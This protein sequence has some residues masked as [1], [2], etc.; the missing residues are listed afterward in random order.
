MKTETNYEL[1]RNNKAIAVLSAVVVNV[2][3]LTCLSNLFSTGSVEAVQ[4][5]Q[6]TQIVTL[7]VA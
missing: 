6:A 5:S 1:S 2:V 7:F 3:V 4:M